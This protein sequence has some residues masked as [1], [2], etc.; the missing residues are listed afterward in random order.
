MDSWRRVLSVRDEVGEVGGDW[1]AWSAANEISQRIDL[2][3][4]NC[5]DCYAPT[6]PLVLRAACPPPVAPAGLC[7]DPWGVLRSPS[8]RPRSAVAP[9][10]DRFGGSDGREEGKPS[11][12]GWGET[13]PDRQPLLAS[14]PPTSPWPPVPSA[15]VA[16]AALEGGSGGVLVPAR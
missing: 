1:R 14:S 15:C 6:A 12:G 10:L 4:Q 5:S 11:Q 9:P 2:V 13:E 8:P 16:A 3:I 7:P